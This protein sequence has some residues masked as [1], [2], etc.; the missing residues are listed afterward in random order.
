MRREKKEQG[1]PH[2]PLGCILAAL[3]EGQRGRQPGRDGIPVDALQSLSSAT[4]WKLAMHVHEYLTAAPPAVEEAAIVRPE[5]WQL[6]D[7]SGIP[8]EKGADT[9]DFQR[10]IAGISSMVQWNMRTVLENLRTWIEGRKSRVKTLGGTPGVK[11]TDVI[12][13]VRECFLISERWK[14]RPLVCASAD[15]LQCFDH[16]LQGDTFKGLLSMGVP[17]WI[18]R[19]IARE[20]LSLKAR[21]TVRGAE[22]TEDLPYTKVTK[23]GATEAPDL[24]RCLLQWALEPVVEKWV[25]EGKGFPVSAWGTRNK[26]ISTT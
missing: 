7:L 15:I 26:I 13:A 11:A 18:A 12:G 19:A 25:Q 17:T 3:S 14:R 1:R 20:H 4:Q 8:R 16:M 21:A 9:F 10:F 24:L 5:E 23:T 2:L 6:I 22:A